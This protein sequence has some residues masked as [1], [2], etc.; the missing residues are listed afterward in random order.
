[1]NKTE[2]FWLSLVVAVF[3]G[4]LLYMIHRE[5]LATKADIYALCIDM[6]CTPLQ[7]RAATHY[8]TMNINCGDGKRL[9]IR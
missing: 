7:C 2:V 1:M 9:T 8:D 3:A 4:G 6:G 5:D